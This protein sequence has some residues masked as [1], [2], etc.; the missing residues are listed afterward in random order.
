MKDAQAS[1]AT[2]GS[3][4]RRAPRG[5]GSPESPRSCGDRHSCFSLAH[6]PRKEQ[7]ASSGMLGVCP[8][9]EV[10]WCPSALARVA[11][12]P[13]TRRG[14]GVRSI[15]PAPRQQPVRQLRFP[16]RARGV[17]VRPAAPS[18]A[19]LILLSVCALAK[20]SLAGTGCTIEASVPLEIY[21]DL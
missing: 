5:M 10:C 8:V 18:I 19:L 3:R 11:R 17:C 14:R 6:R 15:S 2:R 13:L 21:E 20:D 16:P 9:P 7:R 4:G 1:D 12:G